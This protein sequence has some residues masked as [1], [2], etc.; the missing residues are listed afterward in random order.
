MA[1][2]M[3]WDAVCQNYVLKSLRKAVQ[4]THSR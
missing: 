4:K 2:H 3:G 1:K